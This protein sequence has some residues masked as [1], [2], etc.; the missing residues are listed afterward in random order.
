M[1]IESVFISNRIKQKI[2]AKHNVYEDEINELLLY[3]R[4][5]FRKANDS[6]L[7]IGFNRRYL[8]IIFRYKEK[9]KQA[10]IITAY[11]SSKWQI[12]LYKKMK[13]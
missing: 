11:P 6:Y 4:P 1:I 3:D 10:E 7:C 13:K 12:R 8:T 9:I 2:S 5:I